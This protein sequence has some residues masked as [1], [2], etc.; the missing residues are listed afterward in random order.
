VVIDLKNNAQLDD[1]VVY[2]LTSGVIK[3]GRQ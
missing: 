1:M 3:S 2:I